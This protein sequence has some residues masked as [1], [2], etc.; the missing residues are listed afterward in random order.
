VVHKQ[1][2]TFTAT[3]D[4]T[5]TEF[6]TPTGTVQFLDGKKELGTVSLVEGSGGAQATLTVT[7]LRVGAD[8][9]TPIY[10]ES[11]DFQASTSAPITQTV[12]P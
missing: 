1:P 7:K 10:D 8:S 5:T 4:A 9:I 2:V 6:G 12:N 11:L 3:V